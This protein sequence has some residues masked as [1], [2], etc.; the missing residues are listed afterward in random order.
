VKL[1]A[2]FHPMNHREIDTLVI[3]TPL[4]NEIEE[5][6]T[7]QN[8]AVVGHPASGGPSLPSHVPVEVQRGALDSGLEK[9]RDRS[10]KK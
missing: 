10:P 4:L 1:Y 5:K 9:A 3:S 2:S 8:W 6:C 7:N